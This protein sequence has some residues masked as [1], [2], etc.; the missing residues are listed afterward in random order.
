MAEPTDAE[1]AE[2]GSAEASADA[3]SAPPSPGAAKPDKPEKFFQFL[4]GMRQDL[5]A[6]APYYKSDWG[7]PRSYFT[8]INAIFFAFVVQLIPALIF[9]ELMDKQTKGNLAAAETLLSAGIIGIIYAII[10]GQPLTLL[11]ITGPVAIL[12]GTSYGLAEQFD[13]EYW[14]FFWWLCIWTAVLH[15]LTAVTGIVNFVW[16]IS[17][18]TTQIFEFFIASSFIFE[19][20]RDLVEPL[21]LGDADYTGDRAAAYASLVIGMLAFS[22]CWRLHFAETWQL[23]SR[24]IRTFL[25][26]Y[27][28]AIVTIIV[29]A[30]SFLPGVNLDGIERVHVVAPWNWQPSVNAAGETRSWV[31]NPTEGIAA[32]G[33][34][35]A[36]FPA[37]MLYLLFFIDHN[38]S[39]ILT[40]APKYNL[41]KPSSYHWDFFCLGVTIVPCG[42][43]GLPPGSGLIPQAPLH[44]RALATRKF[45]EKHGVRQEVTV[46]VEEQR[47]SA[48]GQACMM[49]VALSLFTVISWIPKGALFGVFLYLGVGAMHGNE[50]WHHITLSFMYAKKRPQ[51]PIVAN[52]NW[53]TVQLYTLVQVC[54]GAAIFGVAQFASVGYIFPALVAALVPI[55]SFFVSRCFSEKDLEYLDPISETEEEAHEEKVKYLEHKASIDEA[56]VADMPGFSDFKAVGMQHDIEEKKRRDEM[57]ELAAANS[58]DGMEMTAESTLTRRH[59]ASATHEE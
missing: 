25:T 54:C 12:L 16:H 48:L 34:F 44:T 37:F 29:T 28:M 1:R 36:L 21:H 26:S 3:S 15:F 27:N 24:Q 51:V 7:K 5:H 47:W 31:I 49:F 35:G 38:I 32:K 10:S 45:V 46:H 57:E 30:L 39:S 40:Q 41:K 2:T 9:A 4:T 17:P 8:V 42:I 56:E 20:I 22:L 23:F 58:G 43:L 55:R 18:F 52:V 14:P 13:S 19:S 11:G 50:I 53:R 59:Q 33:I 6:R